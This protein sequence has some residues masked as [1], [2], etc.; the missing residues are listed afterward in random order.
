MGNDASQKLIAELVERILALTVAVAIIGSCLIVAVLF[1]LLRL[2]A[3]EQHVTDTQR[4]ASRSIKNKLDDLE[5]P[6]R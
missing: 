6:Q 2:G 1:V 3:L 4:D 5:F